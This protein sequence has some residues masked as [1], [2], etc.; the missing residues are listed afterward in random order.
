MKY[1]VSSYVQAILVFPF[2]VSNGVYKALMN[3]LWRM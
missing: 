3:A 1:A 2:Y